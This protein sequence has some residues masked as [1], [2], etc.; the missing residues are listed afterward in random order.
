MG[1]ELQ[2]NKVIFSGMIYEDAVLSVRD[3]LQEIAP[4]KVLFDFI[5]CDDIHLAVLQIVLAYMKKYDGEYRFSDEIKIYQKV[6]EG[7]EKSDEHCM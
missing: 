1:L 5:E 7:F 4:Q 2:D 6:C 3:Y